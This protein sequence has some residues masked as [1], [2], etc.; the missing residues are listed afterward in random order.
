LAA[1]VGTESAVF[2]VVVV[3]DTDASDFVSRL[4]ASEARLARG[5]WKVDSACG[6]GE[7]DAMVIFALYEI[8][9]GARAHSERGGGAVSGARGS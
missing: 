4:S 6:V 3:V 1:L 5:L 2:A 7:G 9:P 8:K